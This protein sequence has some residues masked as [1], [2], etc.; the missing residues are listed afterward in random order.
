MAGTQYLTIFLP[1]LTFSITKEI[2]GYERKN[3]VPTLSYSIGNDER[4]FTTGITP[5]RAQD[6]MYDQ[7]HSR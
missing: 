5:C 2:S 6:G 1:L 7:L 4:L 3:K